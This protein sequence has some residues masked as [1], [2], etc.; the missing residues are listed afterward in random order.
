VREVKLPCRPLS[1]PV[2]RSMG[3]YAME[4]VLVGRTQG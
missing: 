2:M 4:S 1:L 3:T